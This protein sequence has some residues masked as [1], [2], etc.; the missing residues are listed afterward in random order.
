[1]IMTNKLYYINLEYPK[2]ANGSGKFVASSKATKDVSAIL[3]E[4]FDVQNVPITR[5]FLNKIAGSIEFLVTFFMAVRKIPEGSNVFIQYP[6]INLGIFKFC[7]KKLKK[8][9]AI[10]IVHDLQSYRFPHFKHYRSLE[11][12][13]LNSFCHVIVH[14]EKMKQKLIEDGVTTDIIVLELFD[15]LLDDSVNA[16]KEENSIVFAGALEKSLFLKEACD[17][18]FGKYKLNLYGKNCPSIRLNEMISYKGKFLPDDISPIVGDWGLLWDGDSAFDCSGNFGEYLTLIAPH[19]L[20]LYISCGFKVIAWEKSAMAKFILD[21][22]LGV[23][24]KSLDEIPAKL[25]RLDGT[26]L[27]IMEENVS[28]ISR[29]IRHGEKFFTALTVALR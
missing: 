7:Y 16:K 29:Q 3:Q 1:M 24:I 22:N 27:K 5:H 9:N 23:V 25:A 12:D 2:Q 19:K 26:D 4:H 15:Y 17:I 20:S 8:Y 21:N 18:D 11:L 28:R 6:L 14:S 10:T 13:I